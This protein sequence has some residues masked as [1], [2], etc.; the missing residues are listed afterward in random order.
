MQKLVSAMQW[1]Y[2]RLVE[3]W[4]IHIAKL[5]QVTAWMWLFENSSAS[6]ARDRGKISIIKPDYAIIYCQYYRNFGRQYAGFTIS[7]AI[8][9]SRMGETMW[10]SRKIWVDTSYNVKLRAM[11]ADWILNLNFR[12]V[13]RLKYR[14][15]GTGFH[16][17]CRSHVKTREKR[18]K[19]PK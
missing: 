18:D 12:L 6:V 9:M 16:G 11:N 15:C 2:W 1:R 3:F 10:G 4:N 13:F 19:T 14:I 5:K 17:G 8:E 7:S